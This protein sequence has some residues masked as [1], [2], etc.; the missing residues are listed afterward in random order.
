MQALPSAAP[1]PPEEIAQCAVHRQERQ[2]TIEDEQ[3]VIVD[4]KGHS[5]DE[6]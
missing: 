5:A 3:H 6:L 4:G 1:N 2:Y